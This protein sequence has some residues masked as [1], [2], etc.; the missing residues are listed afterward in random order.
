MWFKMIATTKKQQYSQTFLTVL[1]KNVIIKRLQKNSIHIQNYQMV[2]I[3]L[4]NI[5]ILKLYS[6]ILDNFSTLVLL[7]KMGHYFPIMLS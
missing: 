2:V 3:S 1:K 5:I 4:D 6:Q 7:Y